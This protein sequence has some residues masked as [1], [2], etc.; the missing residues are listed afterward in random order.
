MP[1]FR[2]VSDIHLEMLMHGWQHY[3]H[4][5]AIVA[6]E[7]RA[8]ALILAGDIATAGSP[9]LYSFLTAC[10]KA[11]EDNVIYVPGN[12]EYWGFKY[13]EAEEAL[14]RAGAHQ[15]ADFFVCGVR[16]LACTLWTDAKDE[17]GYNDFGNIKGFSRRNMCMLHERDVQ[18]LRERLMLGPALVV[19]HHAPLHD[20]TSD[21]RYTD[22]SHHFGSDAGKDRKSVV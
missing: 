3:P 22:T 14:K 11:Y 15:R 2:V 16:V 10:R 20:G 17:F 8:D 21:A 5:A 9:Q 19:T 13:H 7:P 4:I 1:T 12:H 18:W 6:N